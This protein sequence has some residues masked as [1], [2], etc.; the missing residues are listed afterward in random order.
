MKKLKATL[1]KLD[2]VMMVFDTYE[3]TADPELQKAAAT[4]IFE[5]WFNY[6]LDDEKYDDYMA[7]L[8]VKREGCKA[9]DDAIHAAVADKDNFIEARKAKKA[10]EAQN[11]EN[12]ARSFDDSNGDSGNNGF[13]NDGA[14]YDA[15]ATTGSGE[16]WMNENGADTGAANNWDGDNSGGGGDWADAVNESLTP[17]PVVSSNW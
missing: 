13:G 12:A 8:K 9:L 2:F 11:Q 17:A 6:V 10:L 4:V 7:D 3:Q 15:E 14:G 16:A 1:P 5:W